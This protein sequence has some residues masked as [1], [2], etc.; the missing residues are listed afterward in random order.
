MTSKKGK[1]A[2]GG[3]DGGGGEDFVH[4]AGAV[5]L[6]VEGDVEEAEGAEGGGDAV[7][8]FDVEGAGE[9]GAGDFDAGEVSVVADSDLLEAEG[10][11]GGFGLF[12]LGEV[13]A[14]DGA[15]VL[16]AGGEA[17][18]GG[19]VPEGEVGLASEGADLGLGELGGDEGRDGV[20]LRGGLL[21]GAEVL[22]RGRGRR[23]SCRRRCGRSRV[24]ARSCSI[25]VKSSSLQWKQRWESLRW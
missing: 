23:G 18:A 25:W 10:V 7:E 13:F 5:A 17:G 2:G 14:G 21:A 4:G 6:G 22:P 16:D 3:G 19:L 20:M 12:D 15:A 11:Q 24:S 8:G 9:F 1:L